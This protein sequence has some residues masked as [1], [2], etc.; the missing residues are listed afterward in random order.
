MPSV[1]PIPASQPGSPHSTQYITFHFHISDATSQD[2]TFSPPKVF[3]GLRLLWYFPSNPLPPPF[4]K[5][6][7]DELE[8]YEVD[9]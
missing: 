9:C 7:S 4:A 1:N 5:N 2:L 6:H 3:G 8:V